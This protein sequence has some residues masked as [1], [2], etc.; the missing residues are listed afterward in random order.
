MNGLR[1][2]HPQLGN[3][4]PKGHAWYVLTDKWVLAIKY[5]IPMLKLTDPKKLNK[6]KSPGEDV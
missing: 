4:G 1:K 6:K 3:P 5:S 2:Y